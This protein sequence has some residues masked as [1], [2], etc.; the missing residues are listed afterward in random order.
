MPG[1]GVEAAVGLSTGLKRSPVSPTALIPILFQL[2]EKHSVSFW[3]LYSK[4]TGFLKSYSVLL[5]ENIEDT[6]L[7]R[8]T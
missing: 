7:C 5:S 2:N 8:T 4:T 1:L 3:S 6:L